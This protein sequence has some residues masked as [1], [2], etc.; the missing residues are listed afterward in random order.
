MIASQ[1]ACVHQQSTLLL[2][3]WAS[4]KLFLLPA[5]WL[6]AK[7]PVPSCA[8]EPRLSGWV[9]HAYTF[10]WL[11]HL[12]FKKSCSDWIFL[13]VTLLITLIQN[14]K[15]SKFTLGMVIHLKLMP[16][17]KCL[18]L[19]A[20]A[21]KRSKYTNHSF[22]LRYGTRPNGGPLAPY[23]ILNRFIRKESWYFETRPYTLFW[24]ISIQNYNLYNL[25]YYTDD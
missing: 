21:Q 2:L 11:W 25:R 15:P 14:S 6:A 12:S 20:I 16:F 17:L 8:R 1:S 10:D 4:K 18:L 24:M 7:N 3:R 9:E 23:K 5:L 19:G 22:F 13:M